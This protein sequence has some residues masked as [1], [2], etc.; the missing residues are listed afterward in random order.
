MSDSLVLCN[1]I[2]T[3]GKIEIP[4]YYDLMQANK[5]Q[6]KEEDPA[7]IIAR[8]KSKADNLRG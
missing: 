1:R 8:M 7:E 4:R 6:E 3:R 5:R 2:L